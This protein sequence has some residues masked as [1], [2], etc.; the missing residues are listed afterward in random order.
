[1]PGYGRLTMTQMFSFG[2]AHEVIGALTRTFASYWASECQAMK[3]ALESMDNSG[4]GRIKLADFYGANAD[5]E[6]RFAESEAYL[7]EFG[8][9]DESSAWKGKQVIIP[10]YLQ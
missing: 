8:V 1:M 6:T 7:R 5:G 4:T 10:N 3:S 9:L 2:D